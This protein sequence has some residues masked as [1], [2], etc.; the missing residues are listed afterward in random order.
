MTWRASAVALFAILAHAQETQESGYWIDPSTGLMWTRKD[1]GRD[2]TW[3]K[4]TKYCRELRLDGYS[5]W[6]LGTIDELE[7]IFDATAKAPG[8]AGKR[9]ERPFTFHVK[10]NL[11]LSGD[12]WSS[13]QRRND[14]GRL[15]GFAWNFNF[16]EGR[17]NMEQTGF[18]TD[19]HALCVRRP[20]L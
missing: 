18:F 4:A 5:D 1:N 12:Q 3:R 19:K 14:R 15:I 2:V 10:G 20:E 7:G 11:F 9:N 6:R 13:S 16:N 17:R 8:R